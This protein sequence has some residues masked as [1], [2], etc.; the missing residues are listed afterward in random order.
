MELE[1][2]SYAVNNENVSDMAVIIIKYP[3]AYAIRKPFPFGIRVDE[4]DNTATSKS[5]H[6]LTM[7]LNVFYHLAIFNVCH[8]ICTGCM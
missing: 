7:L 8:Y 3:A 5:C 6:C 1:K 2:E 4:I